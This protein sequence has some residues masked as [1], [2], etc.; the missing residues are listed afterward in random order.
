M[1]LLHFHDWRIKNSFLNPSLGNT[2]Y[3]S[4]VLWDLISNNEAQMTPKQYSNVN[5]NQKAE[6]Q[7]QACHHAAYIVTKLLKKHEN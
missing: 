3:T 1:H 5:K 6:I 2:E 4:E 7:N